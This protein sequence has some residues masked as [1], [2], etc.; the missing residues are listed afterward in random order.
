MASLVLSTAGGA[1]GGALFGT[2]GAMAGRLAG[3]VAG[4]LIDQ[5]LF[6]SSGTQQ[7]REGPRLRDLDVMVSTEGAPIQRVYGRAR[8]AG[9]VIWATALQEA[10]DT[11]TETTGGGGGKGG[12]GS[13]AS[14]P[15]TTKT[16]TYSYYANIAVGLCEGPIGHVARVFADGKLL[17]LKRINYRVYR[18]DDDQPADPLIVAKEGADNA[19]AYRGLAYIVFERLPVAQF[20]NRIP[21]LSF[22]VM[23]PVGALEQ[24][25]RAVTLIPGATEFGYEPSTVVRV[26]GKGK[27][28]P[29]NRHVSYA[30][31]DVVASLDE[32]QATCP[33]LER[34]AIV[35]TW[36]GNDLR[37]GE[38]RIR[39]GID[40]REKETHGATW[41]VAGV[42]RNNAYRVS[43]VDDRPAFGGTPSDASVRHL[44]EELKSRGLKV[45]LYPFVMMDVPPDNALPDPWTGE[46]PQPAFPWRGEITCFPAPGVE[47]SPDGTSA[48]GAQVDAFFDAG[49]G[50]GWNHRRFILHYATLAKE[51]GGVDAFLIGSEMKSLTR[52]RAASGVYPAVGQFVALASD[53]KEILGND[54]VV[55]YAADWTEYGAHVVDAGANEVRF[56]LDPLWASPDIDAIGID[57]YPPLSDW[58]D[59]PDHADRALADTIHDRE[60]LAA[61]VNGGEA[62]DFYYADAAARATQ[63]RT[64][65]TDG[66]GKPWIYRQKDIWNFWS[67][68]HHERV[69]GVELGSATAWVPQSKPIWLTE[70]GCSAV[71]KGSNQPSVFPDAKSSVGGFPHFSNKRRD[72]LIQR[73][74]LEAVLGVFADESD[75]NPVSPLYGG[76][77]VDPSGIHIW[78]WD[79]RPYPIF[80]AVTD[81][82]SDGPNWETGH[83]LTGRLGASNMEG[84]MS[85]IL[86][87]AGV[88]SCDVSA[89]G[90][91]PDGYVIDRPMSARAAIEPLAQVYAFDAAEED[92]QLVFRPRGGVPVIELAESDCV[93][94]DKGAP[95][96]LLRAQETELPRAVALGFTD[97]QNDYRRSAATSRRLVGGS[98]RLTQNDLAIVTN[99]VSAERRADI[100]LQDVWAGRESANF[101]LPPSLLSLSPGDV[102]ALTVDGRRRLLEVSE[103]VDTQSRAVKARSID[104]EIFNLPLAPASVTAPSVPPAIGPVEVR[105]LDLPSFNGEEPVV[106]TRA[107]I[108]ADPWPGPVAIWRSR[109]GASY[110]QVATA[111][112]PA[113]V[114]EMIDPLPRGPL[115][116]FDD[117]NRVRVQLFGGVLASVSDQTLL[118][119]ANLAALQ[120]PT[121]AYEIFQFANAELVGNGTYELSRL[122]RGQGGSEWSMADL[123]EEGATFVLLD[124]QLVPVARGLEML[125]RPLS[126]RIGAASRDHGDIAAVT[127][128][129]TPQAIALRPYAPVHLRATR[130]ADGITLSWIRRTRVSGDS[131]ETLDVPLGED[132]ERYE[133]DIL[134]GDVVKRV[135]QSATTSV[136]YSS[137]DEID[138]FGGAL[139]TIS[140]R[141][142]QMSATVG[143]GVATEVAL[144]VA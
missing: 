74:F 67:Q 99:G 131:W 15:V 117:A 36:F 10:I 29:E 86:S 135:L 76:R 77:M 59:T 133:I 79:A 64:P 128:E 61:N 57:Y 40:N 44:I 94:G 78:T 22:E 17:D 144:A 92:G 98:S 2:V 130:G 18:G 46:A 129:A 118:G 60:Y 27:S 16:T 20:G 47:G 139:D 41:S 82:W 93:L 110:E 75:L 42:N 66:L 32:L 19:P 53:V 103:I 116:C 80:P 31:S 13:A 50:A 25:I 56:P 52:V 65:I 107:A 37:A 127:A 72:D 87:D 96:R 26:M 69:G 100:W 38:C 142:A 4:S 91:G 49:G 90:E 125:G 102:I 137:D 1:A 23:R 109:D 33:N 8:I 30:D 120:G 7:T 85:A 124:Q 39:P 3:A 112:A 123:L 83:W 119:G 58:R 21:Q 55:T 11:R 106:L 6:G 140:V 143:R 115:G 48:A 134:D 105:L 108:F 114:G 34:V 43:V 89:L 132:G 12:G 45:T 62:F 73:R 113:I 51:A 101:A 136:T 24:Q 122:L 95:L 97:L 138:D 28:A 84:L 54:T 81:V 104:P 35:V 141:I 88:V 14:Q 121:G 9:Q 71:D 68:P 111:V 126:L 70:T 63:T 5:S